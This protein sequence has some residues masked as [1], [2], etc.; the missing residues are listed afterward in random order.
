MK[1]IFDLQITSKFLYKLIVLPW[2]C[3]AR[4]AQSTQGNNFTMSLKD[5]TDF[6][7]ADGSQKFPQINT[8]ILCVCG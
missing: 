5:E 8:I 2:L 6:L 7:P 3:V 4:H 1:L